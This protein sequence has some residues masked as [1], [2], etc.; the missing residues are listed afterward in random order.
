ML[1]DLKE[2]C[3]SQDWPG[4]KVF[5]DIKEGRGVFVTKTFKN[6]VI[7]CINGGKFMNLKCALE[8]LKQPWI[9]WLP[10]W[11]MQKL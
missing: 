8:I 1:T 9:L 10:I 5:G 11:V 7:I 2:K 3:R 4:L 6:N